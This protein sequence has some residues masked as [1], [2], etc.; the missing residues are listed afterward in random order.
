[1]AAALI[2]LCSSSFSPGVPGAFL[3]EVGVFHARLDGATKRRRSWDAPGPG[4]VSP[5]APGV[6][7][8][9][10]Q[11]GFGAGRRVPGH[12]VEAVGEGAGHPAAADDTAAEGGEGFDLGDKAHGDIPE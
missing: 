3:D 7:D 6:G 9:F 8:T 5:G 2:L 11:R 4:P 1:L 12:H 10:A